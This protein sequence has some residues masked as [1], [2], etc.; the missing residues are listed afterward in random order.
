[1]IFLNKFF[2]GV[3]I[4][5][6]KKKKKKEKKKPSSIYVTHQSKAFCQVRLNSDE[7]CGCNC[8]FCVENADF[9]KF[10]FLLKNA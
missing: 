3:N 9:E 2:Q 5:K 10:T 6:K 7:K 4:K 1:M 8:N